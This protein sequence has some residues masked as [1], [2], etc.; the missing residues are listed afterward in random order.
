MHMHSVQV[1]DFP[2]DLHI[3]HLVL[4]VEL[5]KITRQDIL[6][7]VFFFPPELLLDPLQRDTLC[8]TLV[9]N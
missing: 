7:L 4:C 6:I 5:V 9:S 1:L 3:R 8:N 2:H